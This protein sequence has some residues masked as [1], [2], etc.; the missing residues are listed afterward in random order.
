MKGWLYSSAIMTPRALRGFAVTMV[1]WLAFDAFWVWRRRAGA[2]TKYFWLNMGLNLAWMA[3]ALFSAWDIE[4]RERE[5]SK[6]LKTEPTVSSSIPTQP[7]NV[8]PLSR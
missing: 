2:L 7:I 5:A 3:S 8:I 1:P 4:K 6:F